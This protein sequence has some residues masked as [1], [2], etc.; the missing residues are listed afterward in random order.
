[1]VKLYYRSFFGKFETFLQ[2]QLL[3]FICAKLYCLALLKLRAME[4]KIMGVTLRNTK[5]N[6]W[7]GEQTHVDDILV[8]TEKINGQGM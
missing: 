1:M 5:R 4:S 8:E 3:C 6:K 2:L 7:V